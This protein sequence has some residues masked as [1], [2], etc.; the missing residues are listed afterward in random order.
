[1]YNI[2]VVGAGYVGTPY[3]VWLSL[4][5]EVTVV[6]IDRSRVDKINRRLSPVKDKEV[7]D[8][9]KRSGLQLKAVPGKEADYR[10]ADYVLIAAPTNYDEKSGVF[11]TS[12]VDQTIEKV[13]AQNPEACIIIKSTVPIGYTEAVIRR[14]GNRRILF[15][16]EFLRETHALYDIMHP[17]RIVF[18]LD[19]ENAELVRAA[20]NFADQLVSSDEIAVTTEQI[21]VRLVRYAEAEAVK[22][23][24]NTYL[25]MRV[26]FFNELDTFALENGLDTRTVIEGVCDDP[27]IGQSYNNPSFGYGGYCLPKDSR[28]LLS[29]YGMIPQKIIRA[30]VE[31]NDTR[32]EYIIDKIMQLVRLAEQAGQNSVVGIYRLS[33][34]SG[35][36]NSR[37]SASLSVLR[38]L[39]DRGCTV[40][41][42]E[43]SLGGPCPVEGGVLVTEAEEFKSQ[44]GIIVANRYDSYLEDVKERVFTR[45][46]F[47]R[48]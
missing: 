47:M 20:G 45:D 2:F 35:S 5:N 48:D 10:Q 16:P 18:G 15:S 8:Y 43:P 23:F 30:V 17:S 34:K 32:K 37:E 12:A 39:I 6:D 27:R 22:L 36:D 40:L 24:A 7:E 26:S 33:M 29:N 21:P 19:P 25:A 1:M 9:L 46:F 13:T 44:A 14:T 4:H 28:Q 41:I 11:D 38:G 31:A 3:A 42:Y